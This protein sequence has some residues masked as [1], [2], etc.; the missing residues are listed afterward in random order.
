MEGSMDTKQDIINK[1]A[2]NL[3][4]LRH[5]TQVE[6]PMTGKIKFMSQRHLAEFIGSGC[7]QQISKFELG[8]NQMSASQLYRIAKVFDISVD[9][10]FE[11]LTKSDYKKV[12]KYDI[13]A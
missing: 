11:D 5:N 12:I 10:M 9:S 1:L 7:E 13:Y 2:S 6:E 4:Y 8:T 3:R